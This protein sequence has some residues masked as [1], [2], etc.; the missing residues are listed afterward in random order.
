MPLAPIAAKLRTPFRKYGNVFRGA[1]CDS[2]A[3]A[4]QDS[5]HPLRG[6]RAR[7]GDP[8]APQ[9]TEG[10]DYDYIIQIVLDRSPAPSKS[11]LVRKEL[12]VYGGRAILP[13]AE[14]KEPPKKAAAAK[15]GRPTLSDW[16]VTIPQRT[17]W[18]MY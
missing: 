12:N 10:S 8:P 18:T 11:I 9:R 14:D 4:K 3:A 16:M 1:A 5:P 17:I 13:A 6:M 2:A 7:A 15:I